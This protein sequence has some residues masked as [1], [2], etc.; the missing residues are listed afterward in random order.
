M[1]QGGPS[2]LYISWSNGGKL[3]VSGQI[4]VKPFTQNQFRKIMEDRLTGFVDNPADIFC[5]HSFR[6]GVASMLG[7]LGYCDDD[8]QAVGRWSSRA[9]EK[10]LRL[11]RTKRMHIAKQIKLA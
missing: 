7:S 10:Y 9:F 2:A 8:I 4:T 3:T 5:T 6:I 1:L 11:P